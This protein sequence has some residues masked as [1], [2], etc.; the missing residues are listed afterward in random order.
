MMIDYVKDYEYIY[1]DKINLEDMKFE[2]IWDKIKIFHHWLLEICDKSFRPWDVRKKLGNI[3]W[4]N[5]F[6]T[7][8]YNVTIGEQIM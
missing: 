6:K 3:K 1:Y 2:G 7:D 5:P 8:I 4:A